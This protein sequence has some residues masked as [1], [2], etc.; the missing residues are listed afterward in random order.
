LSIEALNDEIKGSKVQLDTVLD[1]KITSFCYP[2]GRFNDRI[3]KIVEEAGY[4]YATSNLRLSN[5]HDNNPFSLSRRSI[6]ASDSMN[7]FKTKIS[8]K[9]S[10]NFSYLS[11][12]LIQKGSFASIGINFLRPGK[13]NF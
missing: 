13:S 11:E 9:S 12:I 3:K 2:Y 5:R 8:L 6:Y 1:E 10:L 4:K 7:N